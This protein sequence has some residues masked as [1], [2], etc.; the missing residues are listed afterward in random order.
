MKSQTLPQMSLAQVALHLTLQTP[1]TITQGLLAIKWA[2]NQ[3]I[4]IKASVLKPLAL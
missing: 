3:M 2:N 1:K 4:F